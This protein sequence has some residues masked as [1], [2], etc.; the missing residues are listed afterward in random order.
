MSGFLTPTLNRVNVDPRNVT[1]NQCV[2]R[3]SDRAALDPD[4]LATII[5][6]SKE[7]F[8]SKY[9]I[10]KT[11][12]LSGEKL[13]QTNFK[14]S[15][16]LDVINT[17]VLSRLRTY[18]LNSFFEQFPLVENGI[19]M[20]DQDT[21][22][23]FESLDQLT[24]QDIQERI[25][26]A[27]IWI[28]TEVNEPEWLRE[29][30]WSRDVILA[31]CDSFLVEA[32][33]A[34]ERD[35]LEAYPGATGGPV[36]FVILMDIILS[37]S[38]DAFNELYRYIQ[39]LDIKSY[40]GEDINEVVR[41]LRV[42]LRRLYACTSKGY[43][44]PPTVETDLIK[45][46]QTTSCD[47]FNNVFAALK[48]QALIQNNSRGAT[49]GGVWRPHG[50]SGAPKYKDILR[51]A[52]AT[53]NEYKD[54]WVADSTQHGPGQHGFNTMN[55]G[56]KTCHICGSDNHLRRDC[57]QAGISSRRGHNQSSNS[58]NHNNS[59]SNQRGNQDPRLVP[60]N[61]NDSRCSK[62]NESPRRWDRNFEDGVT[63]SWCAKCVLRRTSNGQ[64]NTNPGRWTDGRS[65]HYTDEHRGQNARGG[66]SNRANL[67]RNNGGHTNQNRTN[68]P[69]EVQTDSN[70]ASQ[71][72]A[73]QQSGNAS[74]SG[75]VVSL[76]QALTDLSQ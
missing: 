62:V 76:A 32:I 22:N 33:L 13:A 71:S 16:S 25:F 66:N 46:F 38:S 53:Y 29:L 1:V 64:D 45:V 17:S 52:E 30:V 37:M 68:V 47:K 24:D 75:N 5:V 26:E 20:D 8:P 35:I 39:K 3:R 50:T 14:S 51:I 36:T 43:L 23:L 55:Q 69:R 42:N 7:E 58:S 19:W 10:V 54:E 57:S 73:T 11:A 44:V 34:K 6:A 65:K 63:R 2:L 27:V 12:S 15:V 9:Q 74:S 60:P 31:A 4:K 40:E 70:S 49:R 59:R 18:D 41:N 56:G 72:S 67:A 61:P 48:V 28:N 21:L